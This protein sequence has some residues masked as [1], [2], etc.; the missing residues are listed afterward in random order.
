[1]NLRHPDPVHARHLASSL[2]S[3]QGETVTSENERLSNKT[4]DLGKFNKDLFLKTFPMCVTENGDVDINQLLLLLGKSAETGKEGF[5]LIWPGRDDS[6]RFANSPSSGTLLPRQSA[7]VNFELT[8]NV[9]IE[10]DNLEVLKLLRKSYQ[11]KI[12][13]I[14]I[15]PPYNTGNDFVYRDDFSD[16]I[17]NYLQQTGQIDA[18][19]NRLTT[20]TETEG[21][22]HSNWLNMMAPRLYLAKS[23]LSDDGLL[24][25]SIDGNE[26]SRLR[27][28][29][30]YIFGESNLIGDLTVVSNLRGRSDAAHFATAHEYLLVFAKNQE[31]A[32]IRGFE[33]SKEAASA[34]K[35]ADEKGPFKPETLRKRGADS[36]RED[37]PSMYFPIY[38]NQETNSLSL[39]RISGSDVEITP[40]LSDG[41]DGRWRWGKDRVRRDGSTELIVLETNGEPTIYVKMRMHTEDGQTRTTKPKSV[42]I[43]PKYDS[44]AGTR[45][46]NQLGIPFSNPKP[47]EYIQDLVQIGSKDDDLVLDFFAG[48][49]TTA[50][51][52]M[53][54]NLKDGGSRRFILVQLPE[55]IEPESDAAKAGYR[56]ISEMTLERVRRSA[57]MIEGESATEKKHGEFAK[58]D[59]GFRA[60]VL[61]DSNIEDWD[62]KKA[63]E[64]TDSL[65]AELKENRLKPDRSDEDVMFEVMVKYGIDLS[66]RIERVPLGNGFFWDVGNGELVVVTSKGLAKEDL[67]ALAKRKPKAVVILDEAF[68]PEALKTNARATFKDAKIELK[69][70]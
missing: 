17:R 10:G 5:G 56:T 46:T 60:L 11:G 42:W 45:L 1:V 58:M 26:H 7:S 55:A 28:L 24:F 33:L 37:V 13:L 12:K 41:R 9:I 21:R 15:D 16:S 62:A 43:D 47:L 22:F 35:M 20:N 39:E 51:A 19:G 68:E 8:N 70:F 29:G 66:S 67:H 69:T 23:L 31:R 6:V 30:E 50:H 57:K 49:G 65:L 61:R 64:T 2:G 18:G 48:S 40:R 52:V 53:A 38:W 44:S 4:D 25:I 3:N 36:L 63:S 34:Y 54:Q 14:Y 32:N 27:L 59:L